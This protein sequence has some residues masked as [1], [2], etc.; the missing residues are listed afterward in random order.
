MSSSW[1][2][3]LGM[4][5]VLTWTAAAQAQGQRR[6]FSRIMTG[7][8]YTLEC[9]L[10]QITN[11][12]NF[13]AWS[14]D[15]R[16]IAFA[17]RGS[18]WRM[19]L[20]SGRAEELTND[21]GYASMPAWSP[22]GNWIVFT[23]DRDETIHLKLLNLRDGS[24]RQLT[25]GNSINVEP[26]WSPDGTRLAFVS[27]HPNGNYNI[28]MMEFRNGQFGDPIALTR[29]FE[30]IPPTVYY[31]KWALHIHPTWTRD[32]KEL[33]LISNRDNKHGSGGFYRMKAEPDA[34]LERFYYEETTWKAR[35]TLSPDGAKLVYS[36]YLGRQWQQL[37]AIPPR[38]GDVFPLTYG[39]F[40]RTTPRWSPDGNRIAFISN[41]TGDTSLWLFHW[42]GGKLEHVPVREWQWK[43]PMGKLTVRILDAA[44]GK[45]MPGRIHLTASDGRGHAPP[46][47]WFRADWMMFDHMDQAG[48]YHWFHTKG[49]STLD[50]PPGPVTLDASR[51]FEYLTQEQKVTV[52]VD[53][54]ASVTFSLK[55]LD[56][57]SA[58]GWWD[59][60]NHFHMNYSGV[61]FNTPARLMEQAEA[62]DVHVLNNLI[63]NKEQRIPDVMHFSGKPDPVST[64]TRIL[65]H[66]Q[67][68]HPPFW[69][70]AAFL[71]LKEH[72]VI[73]DYVGYQNTIV[74]SLYPT[75]TTA[76][77]SA[78]AQKGALAGYAH[79][80][81][82]H[83]PVDLALEN[84]DFVEV[85]AIQGM[86]PLYRAWNCG[87]KV[88]A[89]A[90]EDA[91]PNFYRSYILA[92]NRVYVNSGKRLDYD[93]WIRAFRQGRSFVTSGPLVFLRVDGKEP[94]D[95]VR[96]QSGKALRV[97]LEVKSIMP[98]LEVDILRNGEVVETVKG[99]PDQR[100]IR[101]ERTIQA[102]HSGWISARVKAQYGRS[103]IRRPFPFA[104]TM[105]VWVLV[106]N[107][108]V[109]S[110]AD[111]QS[112]IDRLD[113]TLERALAQPLW[114]NEE[115]KEATRKLYADARR[116]LEQR[117]DEARR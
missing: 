18:I 111:A 39:D 86:D 64:A 115:E 26:E 97:A 73:P 38:G 1:R 67:E 76:F 45:P 21:P 100:E 44:T 5:A 82:S 68:Y 23:S 34:K 20:G 33:I 78:R 104:A 62:E 60:N 66:N 28:Y 12:P 99:T 11:G 58:R 69:G 4:A 47:S 32:G 105:P 70:H 2:L 3:A 91:F 19:Q 16:S 24:V 43:R 13:P 117:R 50:L 56:N 17:A 113:Q 37:W 31:G 96:L 59:G 108:P 81:G 46:D 36:S 92:S 9:Y 110:R 79:G 116:R 74:E 85:N 6:V 88:V 27:T 48:E 71:N 51:G 90:G 89:S 65:Y 53:K 8:P 63:C 22:D 106:G 112:F 25:S 109:R 55:R 107:E 40:D 49:E 29:D 83:F 75:N 14:P 94:G 98:I 52:S 41:E 35:P 10:P 102:D 54:P 93:E 15:S 114:N 7:E 80:A 77:Q 72:L 61:Y 57:T 103:P 42:F 87:Y 30:L 101:F 95:E 84:V